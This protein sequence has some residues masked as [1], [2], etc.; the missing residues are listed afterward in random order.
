MGVDLYYMLVIL[1]VPILPAFL[2][3]RYLPS[4]GIVKGPFKGMNIK[5]GGAFAGYIAAVLVAWQIAAS[6]LQPTW[7]DNW[8]VVAHV[9]FEG[10]GGNPPVG[11]T[12]VVVRPPSA[13]IDPGGTVQMAVS[14]PR[15]PQGAL[16]IQRL[17]VSY[18]GYLPVTVPLAPTS[19][20]SA[21]YGGEDYQVTFDKATRQI[22]IARPIVLT[23]ATP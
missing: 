6:L 12:A 11:E 4:Y 22:V 18:D 20:S 7:S 16:G 1:L 23:K 2:L 17:I 5:F 15:A 19:T 3:F 9:Q 10:A 14:I 13:A 21:A 8:N